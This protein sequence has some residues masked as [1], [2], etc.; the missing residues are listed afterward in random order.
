M[1][2]PCGSV[3]SNQRALLL[4]SYKYK[5][6]ALLHIVPV[7][8]DAVFDGVLE[9]EDAAFALR[10]VADVRVLLA[11]AH[12]DAL[13]ARAADDRREHGARRVVARK[14]RFAH[15]AP[16]VDHQSRDLL[17]GHFQSSCTEESYTSQHC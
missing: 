17:A 10:L 12:H 4:Y 6:S 7:G 2:L 5:E 13:V 14:A 15:A 11:H 3:N 1:Y 9:R 16:V 8:D